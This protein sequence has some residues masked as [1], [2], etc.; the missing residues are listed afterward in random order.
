M[1]KEKEGSKG[2]GNLLVGLIGGAIAGAAAA[3]L[4]SPKTGKENRQIVKEGISKG[5]ER[6]IRGRERI[7][8]GVD[9]IR[10]RQDSQDPE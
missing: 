8:K 3:M 10:N 1:P 6:I 5:K 7:A 2:K 4:L 9:R